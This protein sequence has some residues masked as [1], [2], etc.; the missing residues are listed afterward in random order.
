MRLAISESLMFS[1]S[2]ISL[3]SW[4][5]SSHIYTAGPAISFFTSCWF[6]PQNEQNRFS[7]FSSSLT[8]MLCLRFG[9]PIQIVTIVDHIINYTIFFCFFT[10]HKK[11]PVG[12]LLDTF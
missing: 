2:M 9:D 4:T 1:S 10:G 7:L 11:I 12:I 3:Q 5:H 6:L 8:D